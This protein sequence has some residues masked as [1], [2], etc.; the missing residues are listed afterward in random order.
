MTVNRAVTGKGKLLMSSYNNYTGSVNPYN[1]TGFADAAPESQRATF[2]RKTYLH[3]IGA[4]VAFA[5]I[6]MVL[7]VPLRSVAVA[8][9]DLVT[10]G[11]TLALMIVKS[12]VERMLPARPADI[13]HAEK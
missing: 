9:I 5:L 4:I 7:L 1:F 10:I 11:S 2:L 12:T 6:E 3:L 13:D 8:M